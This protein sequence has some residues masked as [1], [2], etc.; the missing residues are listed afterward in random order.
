[1]SYWTYPQIPTKHDKSRV[2]MGFLRIPSC[3]LEFTHVKLSKAEKVRVKGVRMACEKRV[4]G[5]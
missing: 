1:M 4:K 5:V 2:H 3:E